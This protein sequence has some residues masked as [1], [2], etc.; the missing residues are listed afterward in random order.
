MTA[1]FDA[2]VSPPLDA[3]RRSRAPALPH[4][5]EAEAAV[6]SALLTDPDALTTVR[7]LV[8]PES[9]HRPGHRRV[10]AAMLA[11]DAKGSGIDPLT[12]ARHLEQQ[13]QLDAAGG[14]AG[15]AALVDAVPTSANVAH[16]AALVRE[17]EA[18]RAVAVAAES[19]ARDARAGLE[20]AAQVARTL[21]AAVLP[22]AA[23]SADGPGFQRLDAMRVLLEI[24]ERAKGDSAEVRSG[25]REIDAHTHGFRAGE[26]VVLGAVPKG[27]KTALALEI[28]RRN[29]LA[30]RGVAI[31]SAEMSSEQLTERLLNADSSV[32]VTSTSAGRLSEAEARALFASAKRIA[33]API[34]VDDTAMPTLD[35]VTARV[36][37]LKSEHPQL[38]LVVVD[39][40]QLIQ[41]RLKGRRGDEELA[42]ISYGLKALAKRC[43]CV[44]LAPCQLNYKDIEDRPSQR[45]RLRDLANS[46]GMLQAADFVA[47]AHR[48]AMYSP[49]A[50]DVIE[51]E[52][53]ACRRVSSFRVVL[54]WDGARMRISQRNATAGV[55]VISDPPSN[56]TAHV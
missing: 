50:A 56:P 20:T 42:A 40:L 19:A 52:F 35:D 30:G 17:C 5:A 10:Y 4:D 34:W 25:F 49:T 55:D 51:L 12:V 28:A 22:I 39:F 31:V 14:H 16:H 53:A 43:A 1:T 45:P 46:S 9:F 48:P 36:T 44:V 13:G 3:R 8:A 54:D 33:T 37:A 29:A 32:P 6:L 41:H 7:K 38:Q 15:L 2:V 23:S 47:L 26:L 24:D 11:L 27:G 18:R 21:Q